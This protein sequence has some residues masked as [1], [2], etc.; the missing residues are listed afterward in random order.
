MSTI[1]VTRHAGLVSW[2]AEQ[3]ISGQI[4]AQ[5]TPDDVLG[6]DVVGVLPLHL[7]AL[8]STVTVVDM[9]GLRVD[10]RGIDLTPTEMDAAGAILT[11]YFVI[12]EKD[13]VC[14]ACNVRYTK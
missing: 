1:I 9:P 2:L 4:I 11:T 13:A 12:K 8:A 6:K 14:H 10:Q 7:A 3:G 5:V